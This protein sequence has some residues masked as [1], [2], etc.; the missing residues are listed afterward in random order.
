MW[1]SNENTYENITPMKHD[2][3]KQLTVDIFGVVLLGLVTQKELINL[4]DLPNSIVGKSLLTCF[5]FAVYY[6]IIQPYLINKLPNF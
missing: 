6:Q 5:G 4:D 3:F 1:Y 2:I